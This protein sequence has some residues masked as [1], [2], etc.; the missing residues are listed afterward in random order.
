MRFQKSYRNK[1][2]FSLLCFPDKGGPSLASSPFLF[3][4]Y[5]LPHPHYHLLLQSFLAI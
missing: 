4:S 2:F 1:L 3:T 5:H